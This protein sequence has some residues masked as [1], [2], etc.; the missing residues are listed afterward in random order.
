MSPVPTAKSLF[1]NWRIS[2]SPAGAMLDMVAVAVAVKFPPP[3]GGAAIVTDGADVY[4]DP[5]FRIVTP[6]TVP[7]EINATAV[8]FVPP[9]KFGAPIVTAAVDPVYPKPW[10]E[11]VIVDTLD[12]CLYDVVPS[13]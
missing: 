2:R 6:D 1:V 8:A 7:L 5:E 9:L 4:P 11:T 13:V 12:P 3:A 10:V